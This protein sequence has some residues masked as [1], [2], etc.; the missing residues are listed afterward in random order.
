MI[1]WKRK[2]VSF[3]SARPSRQARN[4]RNP[5]SAGKGF[6]L[7]NCPDKIDLRVPTEINFQNFLEALYIVLLFLVLKI[8]EFRKGGAGG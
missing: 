5:F 8:S 7:C 2:E 6:S 4:G 1:G 3:L